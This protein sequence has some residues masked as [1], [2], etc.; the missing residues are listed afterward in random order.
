[1]PRYTVHSTQNKRLY[2]Q[3]LLPQNHLHSKTMLLHFFLVEEGLML[4]H[5][6]SSLQRWLPEV[7]LHCHC[8]HCYESL[9]M[10]TLESCCGVCPVCRERT[11]RFTLLHPHVE[12]DNNTLI[13]L[14]LNSIRDHCSEH[15]LLRRKTLFNQS[16]KL[17]QN[18]GLF[19]LNGLYDH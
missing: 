15:D 7:A 19:L 17:T 4:H 16:Q 2:I 18:K 13:P 12:C 3:N 9:L 6:R 10:D 14:I 5:W 1:M 8:R 11:K